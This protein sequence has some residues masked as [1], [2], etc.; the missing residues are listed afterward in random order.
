MYKNGNA[1]KAAWANTAARVEP[2]KWRMQ[3]NDTPDM[4]TT[5]ADRQE[6]PY[7]E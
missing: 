1:L 5:S 7:S 6:F 3:P 4:P 2:V